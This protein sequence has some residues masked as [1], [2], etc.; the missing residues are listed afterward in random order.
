[1]VTNGIPS[2]FYNQVQNSSDGDVDIEGMTTTVPH[3]GILSQNSDPISDPSSPPTFIHGRHASKLADILTQFDVKVTILNTLM[4]IDVA[5]VRKL[6]WVSMLWLLCHD[7][8]EMDPID[9][10]RVHETKEDLF[11]KLVEEL[12]PVAI[13]LFQFYH[14]DCHTKQMGSVESIYKYLHSYS[15]SMPGAIPN[16][17]LAIEEMGQRNAL[18]LERP[19]RQP[20]HRN[21]VERVCAGNK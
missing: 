11:R 20:L 18:L 7:T 15:Y 16:K 14:P 2:D 19:F 10:I 9:V 21:L 13:S 12:L 8:E 1:M 6:L 17:Q 3:F 5:A 4:Q